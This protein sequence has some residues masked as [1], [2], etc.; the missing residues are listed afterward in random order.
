MSNVA[1][2]VS[3]DAIKLADQNIELKGV[4]D[5][6]RLERLAS[7][8]LD[9]S[10]TASVDLRFF[11]DE[12]G[13]RVIKGTISAQVLLECQRCLE[14]VEVNLNSEMS[15]SL[16]F[17]DEQAKALSKSY[18]ALM[19]SANED[20]SLLDLV[21]EE[22]LLCLPDYAYHE[23]DD[24]QINYKKQ[25]DDFQAAEAKKKNAFSVLSDLKLKT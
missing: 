16:V 20:L 21:D 1:L 6:C 5:I 3:V 18:D 10:G 4:F 8:L 23:T 14:P 11:R 12:M 19:V 22:L 24:C 2:P 7:L 17:T 25:D 15:L 13:L 9:K